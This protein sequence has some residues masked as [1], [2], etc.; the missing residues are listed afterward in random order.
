MRP[1]ITGPTAWP[2]CGPPPTFRVD[3]GDLLYAVELASSTQ[4]MVSLS[5]RTCDNYFFGGDAIDAFATGPS[6]QVSGPVWLRLRAGLLLYYRVIAVDQV[7]GTSQPSVEDDHL[8]LLP[9]VRVRR[10]LGWPGSAV[11]LTEEP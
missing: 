11:T 5:G 7:A 2:H 10:P 4:L 9:A 1:T 8:E 6:W 3:A